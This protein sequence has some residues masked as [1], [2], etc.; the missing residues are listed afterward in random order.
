MG[1]GNVVGLNDVWREA[2]N[3]VRLVGTE[4]GYAVGFDPG[5]QVSLEEGENCDFMS[6]GAGGV[7]QFFGK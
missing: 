1:T 6:A 4:N 3:R 5:T 7:R 2:R